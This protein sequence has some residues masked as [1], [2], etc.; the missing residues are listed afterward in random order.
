MEDE[1]MLVR[2]AV[3]GHRPDRLW[4][5]DYGN[6]QYW[7]LKSMLKSIIRQEMFPDGDVNNKIEII[8]G[9]ALGVDTIFAQ[10]AIELK[11]EYG[12]DIRIV[13]AIPFKGQ[14]CKWPALSQ[15]EYNRILSECDEVVYVCDEGYA[16][17]KMQK[18]NEY[19]VDRCNKLIAV[20]NGDESGGT[21]N[22]IKYAKTKRQIIRVNPDMI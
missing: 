14:E 3:T 2:L 10:A 17:W 21:Y 1:K 9:M 8:T 5:Y 6:K 7:I 19:M 18:R 22:C 11:K 16:A 12:N 13:A 4:G 15:A 20:W